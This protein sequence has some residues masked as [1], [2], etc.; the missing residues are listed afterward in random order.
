MYDGGFDFNADSVL[1]NKNVILLYF[2]LL[3]ILV[4]MV[5]WYLKKSNSSSSE[6]YYGYGMPDSY[7]VLAS[8]PDLR[9]QE[10]TGTNQGSTPV[11]MA[12]VKQ[13]Y[14]G[15]LK[16]KERMTAM[17]EAPVFNDISQ[18]LAEYQ[19]ATQ[20]NCA[21]GSAPLPMRDAFGNMTYACD[22]GSTPTGFTPGTGVT[23]SGASATVAEH[24]T[25][26]PATAVQEALLMNQLGY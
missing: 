14:P 12:T 5:V 6:H 21:D 20:F 15:L 17:R 10:F 8:G 18:T 23:D 19:Y 26:S 4:L 3:L 9:F 1:A 22:D 25:S 11:N 16:P 7:Q 2:A 24:A 13:M